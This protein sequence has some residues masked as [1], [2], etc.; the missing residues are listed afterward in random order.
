LAVAAILRVVDPEA[1]SSSPV[2][3]PNDFKGVR[4]LRLI[5]FFSNLISNPSRKNQ[6]ESGGVVFVCGKFT[7]KSSFR[8]AKETA[9]ERDLTVTL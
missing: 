8:S 6:G 7:F 2:A 1:A 5:P 3:H 9:G 4:H